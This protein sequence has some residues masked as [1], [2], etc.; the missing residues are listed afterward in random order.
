LH[1][2][3]RIYTFPIC[4]LDHLQEAGYRSSRIYTYPIDVQGDL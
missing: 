3:K 1:H 4:G 2:S